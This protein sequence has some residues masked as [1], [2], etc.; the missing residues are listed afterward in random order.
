VGGGAG[1]RRDEANPGGRPGKGGVRLEGRSAAEGEVK[2]RGLG[3]G[4]GEEGW[5]VGG[6]PWREG[7]RCGVRV[8]RDAEGGM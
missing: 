3:G 4:V 1:P 2:G 8:V 5:G 7:S 6:G